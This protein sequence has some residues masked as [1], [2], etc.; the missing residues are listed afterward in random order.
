MSIVEQILLEKC[1]YTSLS[2]SPT[3]ADNITTSIQQWVEALGY[4]SFYFGCGRRWGQDD[5]FY[6]GVI[7]TYNKEW[8]QK[9]ISE[10]WYLYDPI[11]R[12]INDGQKN[13]E[14]I[15]YG[16]WKQALNYAVN[17]PL[18]DNPHEQ[19][20]YTKKVESFF[21]Q[22]GKYDMNSG[23][24]VAYGGKDRSMQM[25]FASKRPEYGAAIEASQVRAI[26]EKMHL[27]VL[28]LEQLEGC[29]HC[30]H[31]RV[32][33]H[34]FKADILLTP[35]QKSVLELFLANPTATTAAIASL[36][37]ATPATINHHLGT[38]RRKLGKSQVS[39]HVLAHFAVDNQLL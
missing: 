34:E 28:I 26:V 22:V 37:G 31:L 35:G 25:C 3:C 33:L 6:S 29:T 18:G 36:Y 7:S 12:C 27:I 38:I 1:T 21:R 30:S 14:A 5:V 19:E 24:Y 32:A 15:Q 39:G 13:N 17:H 2:T 10:T 11:I 9:H 8:T 23:I 20:V 16:S 4:D